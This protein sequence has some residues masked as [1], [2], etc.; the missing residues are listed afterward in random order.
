MMV[1]VRWIL[2]LCRWLR[3]MR[4]ARWCVCWFAC[5]SFCLRSSC[6]SRGVVVRVVVWCAVDALSG[7]PSSGD[8]R[9]DWCCVVCG[10]CVLLGGEGSRVGRALGVVW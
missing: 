2:V 4:M 7:E 3:L 10:E 1:V 9:A 8:R 6:G 5:D